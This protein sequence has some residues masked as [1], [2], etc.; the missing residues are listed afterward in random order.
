MLERVNYLWLAFAEGVASA[1]SPPNLNFF[2]RPWNF[3][4]ET[5]RNVNSGG[6]ATSHLLPKSKKSSDFST[7]GIPAACQKRAAGR[8][9]RRRRNASSMLCGPV[10]I[11][12]YARLDSVDAEFPTFSTLGTRRQNGDPDLGGG[13]SHRGE[14]LRRRLLCWT[15][16]GRS[17][18]RCRPRT[19]LEALTAKGQPPTP[20]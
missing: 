20:F 15:T 16:P 2:R 1:A 4:D 11:D 9:S 18:W 3:G 14:T 6:E 19:K 17:D 10:H 8:R 13:E 5:S 7:H 12:A